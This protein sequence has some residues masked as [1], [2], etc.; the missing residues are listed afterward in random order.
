MTKSDFSLYLK[1]A[2]LNIKIKSDSQSVLQGS[3]VPYR[4]I[5][6]STV[7]ITRTSKE[8]IVRELHEVTGDPRV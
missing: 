1:I 6:V 8:S 4:F 5:V 2:N 3:C 7:L